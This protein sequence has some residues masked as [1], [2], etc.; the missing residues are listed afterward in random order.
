[1]HKNPL[2]HP[3]LPFLYT[4]ISKAIAIERDTHIAVLQEH[5]LLFYLVVVNKNPAIDIYVSYL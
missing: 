2:L 5:I 1:M 4:I 3:P